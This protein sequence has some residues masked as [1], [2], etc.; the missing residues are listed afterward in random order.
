MV[1]GARVYKLSNT[2]LSP[3]GTVQAQ[4]APV[5][6]FYI[7]SHGNCEEE[8]CP[9]NHRC[10]ETASTAEVQ[11]KLHCL[12]DT[13]LGLW[14]LPILLDLAKCHLSHPPCYFPPGCGVSHLSQVGRLGLILCFRSFLHALPLQFVVTDTAPGGFFQLESRP[15]K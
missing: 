5:F 4:W 9:A 2:L 3:C 12:Q 15:D 11:H 10:M 13:G 14:S 7:L 1:V 6:N 8:L